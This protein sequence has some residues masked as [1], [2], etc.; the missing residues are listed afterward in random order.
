MIKTK[1][2]LLYQVEGIDRGFMIY[3][4]DGEVVITDC[5]KCNGPLA[6]LTKRKRP[7]F[8]RGSVEMLIC[9]TCR[10]DVSG[11]LLRIVSD[12]ARTLA[13]RDEKAEFAAALPAVE[14]YDD[15]PV[16]VER[17]KHLDSTGP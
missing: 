10:S 11:R 17:M 12:L 3:H 16:T 6:G 4:P 13:D 15:N 5:P 7:D 1:P 9:P 8:K 14:D 2:I